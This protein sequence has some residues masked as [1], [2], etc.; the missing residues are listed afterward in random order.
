MSIVQSDRPALSVTQYL[1]AEQH[2]HVKHEY[3]NGEI[4]AMGRASGRHSL[5]ALD[6]AGLLSAHL[7]DQCQVFITDM[8]VYIRAQIGEMFYYPDVLVSCAEDDRAPY[9][10]EK[11]VL[12]AE[13]LSPSTERIDRYEKLHAYRQIPSLQEYPLIA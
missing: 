3:I 11:P 8:K 9:Y 5:V 12:I 2:S 7:P 10:R 4:Y 13:V 6:L 1:N